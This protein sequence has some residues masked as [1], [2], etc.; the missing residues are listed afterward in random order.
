[1]YFYSAGKKTIIFPLFN[2]ETKEV[3]GYALW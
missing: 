1:M 2:I 3:E